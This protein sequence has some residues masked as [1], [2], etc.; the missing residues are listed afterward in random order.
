MAIRDRG[1]LKWQGAFFMP[2]HVKM[3]RDIERDNQKEK[4]PILD[5]YEIEEIENKINYAMEFA[6]TVKVK[7]WR[8]GFFYDYY[9]RVCRLDMLNKMIYLEGEDGYI[10]KVQFE[11]IV[12]VEV[13]EG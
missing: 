9:G 5:E 12:G 7:V 10:E 2:E 3:L 6:F 4:Q 8:E 13:L 11:D 1:K